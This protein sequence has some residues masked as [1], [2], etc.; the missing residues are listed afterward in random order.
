MKLI[1]ITQK[2]RMQALNLHVRKDQIDYI[3]SVE[4]C[5]QEADEIKA[6][7]PVGIYVDETIV[8]FAMYGYIEESKYSR[9]WFDRLMIDEKYQ[10]Q[11]YGKEAFEQILHQIQVEY[12]GQDIYLSVYDEN[13]QAIALYKKHGFDYT[14]ELDTKGEKIMKYIK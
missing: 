7:H 2:N 1:D 5:L 14:G 3:E 4:E 8:G 6:W 13:V 9:L 11:G 10:Q 12:P